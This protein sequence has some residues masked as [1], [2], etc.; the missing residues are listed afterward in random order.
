MPLSG[1]NY[2][3]FSLDHNLVMGER[4]VTAPAGLTQNADP[5][6][7][8]WGLLNAQTSAA[9][10]FGG[11]TTGVDGRLILLLA[12]G[13]NNLQVDEEN[14]GSTAAFRFANGGAGN[15]SL[16]PTAARQGS[17]WMWCTTPSRFVRIG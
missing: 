4:I 2:S 5:G 13:T 12:N 15:L 14:T 6:T 11:L 7:S 16:G 10:E 1:S 3:K 9:S 17:C 8:L